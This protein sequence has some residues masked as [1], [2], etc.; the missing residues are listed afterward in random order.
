MIVLFI[1]KYE[2][3]S[4]FYPADV[5]FDN[6][7]Y[8]SVENAFQAAKSLDNNE[9]ARIAA[10]T[11]G[12][13]KRL[14]RLVNPLRPDWNQVKVDLMK[15]LLVKKFSKEPFSGLLCDTGDQ[16]LQEGNYWHDNFWGNCLCEHCMEI[17]GE[18]VLGKL[19]ME[20]RTNLN[21]HSRLL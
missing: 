8:H 17:P 12:Q 4:N 11:P 20:V 13:A 18:N 5:E 2:F 1:G 7:I 21:G 6:K 19:L 16:P 3:L 9:R 10:G 14:G 15:E